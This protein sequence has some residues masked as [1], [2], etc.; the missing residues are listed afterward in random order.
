M[1]CSNCEMTLATITYAHNEAYN[2]GTFY[3]TN[4]IT[5][6]GLVQSGISISNSKAYWNGGAFYVSGTTTQTLDISTITVTTTWASNFGG[7]MYVDNPNQSL[8]AGDL[9]VTSASSSTSGGVFYFNQ[10]S[11]V[12]IKKITSTSIIS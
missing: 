3:I 11:A 9:S 2:G 7:M 6:I 5:P 4:P 12:T 8:L 10:I 1:Y